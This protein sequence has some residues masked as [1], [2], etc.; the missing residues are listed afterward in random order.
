MR[1]D[2]TGGGETIRWGSIRLASS[3]IEMPVVDETERGLAGPE[4]WDKPSKRKMLRLEKLTKSDGSKRLKSGARGDAKGPG[5]P[6][7]LSAPGRALETVSGV[8]ACLSPCSCRANAGTLQAPSWGQG[9]SSD[10][11]GPKPKPSKA[12]MNPR[13]TASTWYD[14]LVCNSLATRS[15]VTTMPLP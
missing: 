7:W 12:I 10:T 2:S 1:N 14:C 15:N 6:R 8:P 9:A 4:P 5:M 3:P 11:E 13:L